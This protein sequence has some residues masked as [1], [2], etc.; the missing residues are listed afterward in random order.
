MKQSTTLTRTEQEEGEGEE[1]VEPE[2]EELSPLELHIKQAEVIRLVIYLKDTYQMG[3][4]IS[5]PGKFTWY[6]GN[7]LLSD[8]LYVKLHITH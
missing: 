7:T 3:K 2:E 6:L 5:Q 4:A 1:I 8:Q